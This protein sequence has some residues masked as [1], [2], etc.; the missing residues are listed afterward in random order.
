M[1]FLLPLHTVLTLFIVFW[2]RNFLHTQFCCVYYQ[3]VTFAAQMCS[4]I[5]SGIFLQVIDTHFYKYWLLLDL[6][7][8][9][10]G[11]QTMAR[12]L[13]S[14]SNYLLTVCWLKYWRV[15]VIQLS[16]QNVNQ[17]QSYGYKSNNN[18]V[19]TSSW[20]TLIIRDHWL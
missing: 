20:L 8:S 1:V 15:A 7:R 6:T 5:L 13:I 11:F 10:E 16:F 19:R 18:Y 9:K 12:I 14:S 2:F 17:I 3:N 4:T